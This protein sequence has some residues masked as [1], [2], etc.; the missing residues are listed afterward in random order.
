MTKIYQGV[1]IVEVPKFKKIFLKNK[2]F[3]SDIFT[4]K[5]REYCLSRKDPYIHFAG[6]FAAKEASLKA[7][8]TGLSGSGID[9][10][11]QE[12]EV[13]PNTSGNPILYFSGWAEKISKKRKINQ[14]TVSISHSSNYAVA[15]VILAGN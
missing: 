8:G 2:D 6:R 14:F 4:K 9:H 5:E 10:I 3:A 13:V 12:I 1:D 7:L 15:T 11:F